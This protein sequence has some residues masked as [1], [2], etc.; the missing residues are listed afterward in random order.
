MRR[1]ARRLIGSV[2][3]LFLMCVPAFAE[4]PWQQGDEVFAFDATWTKVQ[5]ESA[6]D[7][8][9]TWLHYAAAN[10]RVGANVLFFDQGATTGFGVGP[11]YEY[12]FRCCDKGRLFVGGDLS[13][14]GDALSDAGALAAASRAGYEFYVGN[15]AAVRFQVRWQKVFDVDNAL[16]AE[17]INQYGLNIGILLGAPKNVAIN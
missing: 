14:L 2:A 6:L 11:S 16:L 1:A 8:R 4:D 17:P 9:G 5:G 10:H 13:A 12:L 3:I 7:L 15:S